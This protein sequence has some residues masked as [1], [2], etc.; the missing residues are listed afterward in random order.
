MPQIDNGF[1]VVASNVTYRGEAQFQCY[2]GF[3]FPSGSPLEQITCLEDG[4]WS[5]LPNCQGK[6]A[7][8]YIHLSL[9]CIVTSFLSHTTKLQNPLNE[10]HT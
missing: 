4:Q 9:F 2:A 7:C 1:A 5:P 8:D 6:Q 10:P 3:A